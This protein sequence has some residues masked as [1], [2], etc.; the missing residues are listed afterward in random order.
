MVLEELR[1]LEN[2]AQ[3]SVPSK[4]GTSNK[5]YFVENLFV[6]LE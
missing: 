2:P 6:V 4:R 5:K 1:H 3:G